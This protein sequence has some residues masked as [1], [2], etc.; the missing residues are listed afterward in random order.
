MAMSYTDW[1]DPEDMQAVQRELERRDARRRKNREKFIVLSGRWI[2][3]SSPE[4][5]PSPPI[6]ALPSLWPR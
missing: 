2:D 4:I 1:E 6:N 5:V 3:L